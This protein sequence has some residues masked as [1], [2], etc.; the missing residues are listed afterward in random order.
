MPYCSP[1][2]EQA[3]FCWKQYIRLSPHKTGDILESGMISVLH[4]LYT[5]NSTSLN[6]FSDE[7]VQFAIIC[8]MNSK[9]Y[10]ICVIQ[11]ITIHFMIHN[12]TFQ[13][14]GNG[15]ELRV[16]FLWVFFFFLPKVY[17]PF[18]FFKI[19]F[20]SIRHVPKPCP[21]SIHVQN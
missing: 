9:S 8:N 10:K 1:I 6:E 12:N 18:P 5:R 11:E 19:C 17:L 4:A 14:K 3:A 20:N 16:K 7:E 15:G 13:R 21:C 2:L